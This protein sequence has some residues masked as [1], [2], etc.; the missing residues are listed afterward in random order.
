MNLGINQRETNKLNFCNS[1]GL[2]FLPYKAE[3]IV[4]SQ[5]KFFSYSSSVTI[6][7][8][9]EMGLGIDPSSQGEG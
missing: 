3:F 6:E 9:L 7:I 1:K 2:L 4:R 8:K 5:S